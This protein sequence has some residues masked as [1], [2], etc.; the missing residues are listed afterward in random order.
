MP[1]MPVDNYVS[2][3][4]RLSRHLRIA[5]ALLMALYLLDAIWF[6]IR[7][8]YPEAGQASGSVH[9]R[10]LL[11]IADKGGKTE[12]TIDALQPEEDIPCA[13][14]LFPHA[15]QKPCWYVVRHANDPIPM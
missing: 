3:F 6:Y 8:T 12:Y 9:R 4:S 15:G 2:P 10:R 1:S 5:L 13:H 11:A 7:R 14:S